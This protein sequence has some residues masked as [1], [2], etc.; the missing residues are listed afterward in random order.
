M[1]LPNNTLKDAGNLTGASKPK[2]SE[3]LLEKARKEPDAVIKDLESRLS[4]LSVAE[5]KARVKHYG[6]NEIA[7]E[8]PDVTCKYIFPGII[9]VHVHMVYL[10]DLEASSRVAAFGGTMTLLHFAYARIG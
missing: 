1:G 3:Q 2:V 6:L 8:V 7:R 5:A 10:D 4:G 9:D